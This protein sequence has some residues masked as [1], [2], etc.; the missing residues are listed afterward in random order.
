MIKITQLPLLKEIL[1]LD[2]YPD[3]HV[4]KL[5]KKIRRSLLIN[6]DY[7]N[8]FGTFI[9][10]LQ[11]LAI[12]SFLTEYLFDYTKYEEKELSQ[13]KDFLT[14]QISGGEK[15]AFHFLIMLS[16]QNLKKFSSKKNVGRS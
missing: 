16:Y 13:V 14:N 10:L 5:L 2:P 11:S 1:V 6:R 15:Y 7:L 3:L 4:E 8:D 9:P 12:N